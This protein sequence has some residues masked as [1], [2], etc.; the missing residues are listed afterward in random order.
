M[1]AESP[2]G[3][4]NEMGAS[5]LKPYNGERATRGNNG[6]IFK[7]LKDDISHSGSIDFQLILRK[8]SIMFR[9]ISLLFFTALFIS[10]HGNDEK[11]YPKKTGIT[12]SVYSSVTIQ[13]D[14][15]YQ[16]YAIVNGIVDKNLVEEGDLVKKGEVVVQIINNSPKLNAEIARGALDLARDNYQGSAGILQ[17]IEEELE[18]ARLKFLD[19]SLNFIRQKRLWEQGIGSKATFEA[20]KLTFELSSSH[21][22]LLQNKYA[23]TRNELKTQLEQAKN[24]YRISLINTTD[25]AVT[26]KIFG[27]VYALH[28]NRGEVVTTAQPLASIGK[29]DE[30]VIEMLVDEVDIVKVKTGQPVLLT[31][32]AYKGEVFEARVNKIFPT[33]D[34]RNQTFLVEALFNDPPAVLYPGLSGE[35]NIITSR[36]ENA[37]VIPRNYLI[38]QDRVK[39]EEGIVQV[40][41]GLQSLDSV[42]ISNGITANTLIYKPAE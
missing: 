34:E 14:S 7:G 40:V 1:S 9:L 26:S 12:E 35:A 36:K 5:P 42:E 20:K 33:K 8:E 25:F 6:K 19:D 22:D 17:G 28:K 10:C 4:V 18:A 2:D 3:A 30:F 13:P 11:I 15:L 21:L 41:T 23:R 31:L 16:A 37:L 29:E 27:K 32:D 39:T 38:G 24:N